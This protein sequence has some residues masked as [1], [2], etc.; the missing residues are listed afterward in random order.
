MNKF[1]DTIWEN[2]SSIDQNFPGKYSRTQEEDSPASYIRSKIL[3]P[4][5]SVTR[6]V[7]T[8]YN[9]DALQGSYHVLNSIQ[10][11][12]RNWND[13]EAE[14]FSDDLISKTKEILPSLEVQ[15]Q[16]FP[17]ARNSI[18]LEYEK[19]NNDYL[20]F[21]IYEDSIMYYQEKSQEVIEKK[22]NKKDIPE[23]VHRFHA[24]R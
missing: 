22:I 15:P 14:P 4:Y 20:E 9:L 16:I 21:E 17:T 10:L 6:R 12:E 23:L 18:Q 3:I 2:S 8:H 5:I 7:N 11:L 13:N 1:T 24:S 19:E